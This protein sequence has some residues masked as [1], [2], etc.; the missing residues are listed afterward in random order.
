MKNATRFPRYLLVPSLLYIRMRCSHLSD[1][2]VGL[3][4]WRQNTRVKR[5]ARCII[6]SCVY[7][8][9]FWQPST[10]SGQSHECVFSLYSNPPMHSCSVAVPFQHVQYRVQDVS[11]P[12]MPYSQSQW[13]RD[14]GPSAEY[15]P[16]VKYT[17]LGRGAIRGLK[18]HGIPGF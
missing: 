3:K 12:N 6:M 4:R 1:V 10:F 7:S 5:P 2:V 9:C 17:V 13:S 8:R 14:I 18:R 16:T 15:K 11:W